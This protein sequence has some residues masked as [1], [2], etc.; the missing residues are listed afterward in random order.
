M[1]VA[2]S[3]TLLSQSSPTASFDIED[4]KGLEIVI[5]T[6]LLTFQDSNETYHAPKDTS[7]S[8]SAT[9]SVPASTPGSPPTAEPP[10][11][12][13]RPEPR[14]GLDRVSELHAVRSAQG[15]GDVNEVYV[16]EE[17]TVEDYAQYA[18]RLLKVSARGSALRPVC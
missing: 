17:C 4:R 5:L 6:A 3:Y 8:T 9:G 1:F 12:P 13:P 11:V 18:E 7:A 2:R 14:H 10:T 16:S 15:E